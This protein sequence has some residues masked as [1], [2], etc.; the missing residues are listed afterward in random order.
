VCLR[1]IV[2]LTNVSRSETES[3]GF[4]AADLAVLKEKGFNIPLTFIVNSEALEDFM[5]ENGLKAKIE[6]V[7]LE[8][9]NREEAYSEIM[10]LFV[11]SKFPKELEAELREAYE[12]L[13]VEPGSSANSIISNYDYPFVTLIRSPSY[14][15]S[16]EDEEGILQNVKGH[17]Q[18][19]VALKLVWSTLFSQPSKNYREKSKISENFSSSIIIQKMKKTQYS[20]V[21]YSRTEF[22]EYMLRVKS[23][24]GLP[25]YA[26]PI[27][28]K[29]S[30]EVDVNSLLIRTAQVNNQE[31][32]LTRDLDS[33]ELVKRPLLE[34]G[35]KQKLN[36]KLVCE[37][38]RLAKRSKSFI[39]RDVKIYLSIYDDNLNIL[40]VNRLVLEQKKEIE[41][42]ETVDVE[43]DAEG[44]TVI[45]SELERTFKESEPKDEFKLPN[46][47][48]ADEA[49]EHVVQNLSHKLFS[50]KGFIEEE[51]KK[52]ETIAG[53]ATEPRAEETPKVEVILEED[54]QAAIE[55]TIAEEESLLEQVLRIK[56]LIERMEE[57]ALNSNKES[58]EQE[59]RKIKQMLKDIRDS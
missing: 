32:Q 48:S 40:Q 6:R 29:D 45:K 14:I 28:G 35:S 53:S 9:P 43:T 31:Y 50:L 52:E 16:H 39:G 19:F 34:D 21:A 5:A 12:S 55:K 36:D 33:E 3:I 38:A 44:K 57:H 20:A 46:L 37:C 49:K 56:E 4:R 1:Y 26:E 7:I 18:L 15:L 22:N 47:I 23:Y 8:K 25:D 59:A 27:M 13:S 51:I 10:N 17:E 30:Y 11:K 54:S 24:L 42:K 41:E 2:T 58:Y